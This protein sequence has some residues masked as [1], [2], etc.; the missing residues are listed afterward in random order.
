MAIRLKSQRFLF[1]TF[2]ITVPFVKYRK[3]GNLLVKDSDDLKTNKFKKLRVLRP[4]YSTATLV[5]LKRY[6]IFVIMLLSPT[7]IDSTLR[8][9]SVR[10]FL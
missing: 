3:T 8:C 2:I 1:A 9:V 6:F 7:R 10:H 5:V 4:I